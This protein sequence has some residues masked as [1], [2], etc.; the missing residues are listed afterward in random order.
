MALPPPRGFRLPCPGAVPPPRRAPAGCGQRGRGTR[1]PAG[2]PAR[3]C[4]RSAAP[5]GPSRHLLL[6]EAVFR[7]RRRQRE[8]RC[9]PSARHRARCRRVHLRPRCR[10]SRSVTRACRPGT[11]SQRRRSLSS[12]RRAAKKLATS[13]CSASETRAISTPAASTAWLEPRAPLATSATS[14]MA[15]VAFRSGVRQPAHSPRSRGSPRPVPRP[16]RQCRRG[17]VHVPDGMPIPCTIATASSELC[18]GGDLRSDLLGG[19][20]GLRRQ[21]F[22][23]RRHHGE[24]AAG[25]AGARRLDGGVEREQI[26]L[27]RRCR[28]S[29]ARH[30]RSVPRR[31]SGCAPWRRL[32]GPAPPTPALS[33]GG[34]PAARSRR[35]WRSTPRSRRPRR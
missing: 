27:R 14:R 13:A 10:G 24:A 25:I 31:R 21:Q 12:E 3:A 7:P 6:P 30:R 32:R 23:L 19:P 34:P 33:G 17:L 18:D 16:P 5:P 29:A 28:R 20:R 11:R 15:P 22:D 1:E 26:G 2:T 4:R 35:R 9:R 8:W